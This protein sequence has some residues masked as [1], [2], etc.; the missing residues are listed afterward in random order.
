MANIVANFVAKFASRFAIFQYE[1]VDKRIGLR[2]MKIVKP[3]ENKR[4]TSNL[5]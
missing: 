3:V 2:T 1:N 4:K 5:N